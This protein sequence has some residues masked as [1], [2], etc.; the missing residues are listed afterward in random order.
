MSSLLHCLIISKW[1]VTYIFAHKTARTGF[2]NISSTHTKSMTILSQHDCK[3]HSKNANTMITPR[4][5]KDRRPSLSSL[6]V[7]ACCWDTTRTDGMEGWGRVLV[8]RRQTGIQSRRETLPRKGSWK[9]NRNN[10][11]C[12]PFFQTLDAE[13]NIASKCLSSLSLCFVL[14]FV[15][16]L[17]FTKHWTQ[18]QHSWTKSRY[19]VLFYISFL[20][21]STGHKNTQ[22][23]QK[24]ISLLVLQLIFHRLTVVLM[25]FCSLISGITPKIL[26]F[27]LI[28]SVLLKF[29]CVWIWWITKIA[30]EHW[31]SRH[32][33]SLLTL[34]YCL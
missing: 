16:V 7:Q 21:Q 23:N 30:F 34:F 3:D 28:N 2:R 8:T 31:I 18:K 11:E 6:T 1:T 20:S 9:R 33:Q 14:F 4:G 15:F 13:N 22:L 24:Q 5:W 25:S 17:L 27:V 19:V 26:Y 10:G 12:Q 29:L 32:D